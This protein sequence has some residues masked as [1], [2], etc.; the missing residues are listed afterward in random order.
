MEYSGLEMADKHKADIIVLIWCK[1]KFKAKFIE[2]NKDIH[3][4]LI[5]AAKKEI[6]VMHLKYSYEIVEEKIDRITR[7]NRK[8][9]NHRWKLE[10]I[11]SETELS[12][13]KTNKDMENFSS[14]TS[15]GLIKYLGNFG[16]KNQRLNIISNTCA[17]VIKFVYHKVTN[18]NKFQKINFKRK[19]H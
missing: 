17:M 9:Q 13:Q 14:N 3:I 6:P 8:I 11:P 4:I 15:R 5:K 1:I 18:I 19:I 2:R 16:S 12:R 7:G 10:Q